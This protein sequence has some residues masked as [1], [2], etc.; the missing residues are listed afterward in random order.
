MVTSLAHSGLPETL[1]KWLV[2]QEGHGVV[3]DL[4]TLNV[5]LDAIGGFFA[6][7]KSSSIRERLPPTFEAACQQ[8]MNPQRQWLEGQFPENVSFGPNG[9]YV[10]VTKGGGGVW[11]FN[12]QLPDL[13]NFL[14]QSKSLSGVVCANISV[15]N[16]NQ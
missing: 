14:Q 6:F 3:R 5:S 9:A 11:N 10:M 15:L 16:S 2:P 8:R 13:Q 4:L 1:R 7:D 12:G